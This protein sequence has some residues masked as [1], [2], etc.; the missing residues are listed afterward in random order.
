MSKRKFNQNGF[1][2]LLLLLLVVIVAAIVLIFLRIKK[3][4]ANVL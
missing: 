3:A 4:H 2:P 1:I